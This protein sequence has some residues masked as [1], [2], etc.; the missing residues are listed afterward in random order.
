MELHSPQA[1]SLGKLVAELRLGAVVRVAGAEEMKLTLNCP[2]GPVTL[3]RP[4]RP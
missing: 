2:A 1:E 4:N 3:G